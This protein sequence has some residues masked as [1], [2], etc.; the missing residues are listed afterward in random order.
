MEVKCDNFHK[1][2]W[3]GDLQKT[4]ISMITYSGEKRKTA[5]IKEK[6]IY[7]YENFFQQYKN[8]LKLSLN[9]ICW[10]KVEGYWL[11]FI[12]TISENFFQMLSDSL[13]VAY[14]ALSYFYIPYNIA[15]FK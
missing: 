11:V 7:V 4:G 9:V 1:F 15:R 10:N 14:L 8:T 3:G 12:R 2:F 5:E 6:V 13:N